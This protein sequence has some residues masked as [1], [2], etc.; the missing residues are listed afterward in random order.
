MNRFRSLLNAVL[1]IFLANAAVAQ[2][3]RTDTVA[4]RNLL[5]AAKQA[6]STPSRAD[7]LAMAAY[8]QAGSNLAIRGESAYLICFVNAP[9][10]FERAQQW[11]DSAMASFQKSGNERWMGYT[12]RVL[13]V[14]SQRLNKNDISLRYFQNSC[15]HFE[16]CQ[17]TVMLAQNYV[18]LS[19]LYHNNLT[20]YTKGLEYGQLA[21]QLVEQQSSDQPVLLW[22]TLNAIAINYDDAGDLDRAIAFHRRNL[23]FKDPEYLNSS[24]NNL[25]NSLRKKKEY[26]AAENYFLQSLALVPPTDH[27][28]LATVYLNLSQVSE[29][30]GLRSRALKY[31]DSSIHYALKSN[32]SEKLRDSYEF[33]H[34][35]YRS[36]GE[37]VKA[38]EALKHYMEIKDSVLSKEKAQVIYEM[39]SKFQSAQKERQIVQ[40]QSETL[41]KDLTIQ[42]S[43][44]LVWISF[45]GVAILGMGAFWFFKRHQYKA[46]LQHARERELQQRQRFSAVIE[47][48]ENERSRVAKELH[49]GLG[50]LI[51][52]AKLGL[53]AIDLPTGEQ[54]SK[55]LA[56]SIHVLDQATQEVRSIAHNLMP[57]ALTER[58]LLP[59]LE[60]MVQKINLAGL[61]D[62]RL[63]VSL[64]EGRLVPTVEVAVYRVIQEV[65]NNMLKHA[66]ADRIYITLR[67]D[68]NAVFLSMADNGVGFDQ[69]LV[70]QSKGLGWKN[71]FSRIAMLNGNIDVQ[72]N[73]GT[74]TSINIQFAIS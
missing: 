55:L 19:L 68:G 57:V 4:A 44:F 73:P 1:L 74:G 2:E 37:P 8:F 31:N 51:S 33:A 42:Q 47:A 24:L 45:A 54:P 27:Y 39:E 9:L 52:T 36:N 48:E 69:A 64:G 46:N 21:L 26:K 23:A 28:M 35:L 10:N 3:L 72:T 49:D 14:R 67:R 59:A 18:N 30:L 62:V 5:E 61:L 70:T 12:Q 34:R 11:G 29:D 22:R 7:S 20:D 71:I 65:I 6:I 50:Q 41:A 56:N 66:A 63:Q 40:L 60:D 13:G 17:D 43:R 16:R 32:H 25:G 15:D 58:G 53:S 38:Y